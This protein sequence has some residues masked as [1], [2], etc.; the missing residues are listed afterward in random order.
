[1]VEFFYCSVVISRLSIAVSLAAK[2]TPL[3]TQE[4]TA[5]TW[6]QWAVVF[7]G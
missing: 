4:T 2:K 7:L 3:T 1:M 6:D 5:L